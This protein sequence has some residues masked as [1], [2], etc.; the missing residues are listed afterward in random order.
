[1]ATLRSLRE[2]VRD[3]LDDWAAPPLWSDSYIDKALNEAVDEA[4]IRASLV[5]DRT[6][7]LTQMQLQPDQEWYAL[8]PLITK[9]ERVYCDGEALEH[10]AED[11]LPDRW[12]R[13]VARKPRGY[14][15][16]DER[17]LRPVPMPRESIALALVVYRRPLSPMAAPDDEPEIP[18]L[19]HLRLIDWAVRC[20][21]LMR[22]SDS[23]NAEEAARF[24]AAFERSFGPRPNADVHRRRRAGRPVT[25]R[26]NPAW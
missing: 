26:I 13:L 25:V 15:L 19:H 18:E 12:P 7:S 4:C 14:L 23:Y 1:M 5:M 11:R 24:E 20:C 6:S 9:V 21:Y 17:R 22:D 8:S 2:L 10:L 3:R 16:E